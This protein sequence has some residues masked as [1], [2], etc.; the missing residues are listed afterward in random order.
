MALAHAK[1][2]YIT[3]LDA[4]PVVRDT[5]G[6]SGPW[7]PKVQEAAIAV[8]SGADILST[9]QIARIKSNAVLKSIFGYSP[10]QGATGIYDIGAYYASAADNLTQSAKGGITIVTSAA[11]TA[12]DYFGQAY[13]T[14]AGNG[15]LFY[16]VPGGGWRITNA[17]P[18]IDANTQWTAAMYNQP[19]WQALTL[20]VDPVCYI[21][22]AISLKEAAGTGAATIYTRVEYVD[23]G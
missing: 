16:S 3:N 20:T 11:I 10:T 6:K 19:I 12:V 9:Y 2:T 7:V 8:V 5:S 4:S 23:V 13:D 15:V 17:T 22:L 14:D 1:S 21:D 18:A